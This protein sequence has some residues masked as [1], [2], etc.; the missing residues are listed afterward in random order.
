MTTKEKEFKSS[1]ALRTELAQLL[2]NPTM[3][4]ALDAIRSHPEEFPA[5]IPGIHY[6]LILSREHARTIGTNNAIKRLIGLT[7]EVS[8]NSEFEKEANREEWMDHIPREMLEMIEKYKNQNK[9]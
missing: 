6:D 1:Q 2:E 7:K 8:S 5:Q 9:Q 3:Q 4:M